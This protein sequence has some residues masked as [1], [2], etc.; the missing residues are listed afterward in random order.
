MYYEEFLQ[1]SAPYPVPSQ[2]STFY[3][4]ITGESK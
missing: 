4:Q 1:T 3:M 2:V